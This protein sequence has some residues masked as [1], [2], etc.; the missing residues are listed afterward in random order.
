MRA[1]DTAYLALQL[2]GR[3]LLTGRED[4]FAAL[5]AD[6]K[7]QQHNWQTDHDELKVIHEAALR[8][9][10]TEKDEDIAAF[11]AERDRSKVDGLRA[12]A[13]LQAQ[14]DELMRLQAELDAF[15]RQTLEDESKQMG[16]WWSR[17]RRSSG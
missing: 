8:N 16:N 10:S 9:I 4:A 1:K 2:E 11:A 3:R 14:R 12:L 6:A 7:A 15:R 17:S 5:E 13:E